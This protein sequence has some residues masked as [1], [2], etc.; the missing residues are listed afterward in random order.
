MSRLKTVY[1]VSPYR[2]QWQHYL[3]P[4]PFWT[5]TCTRLAT[6]PCYHSTHD[7]EQQLTMQQA[8]LHHFPDKQATYKFTLRD[9]SA[10]FTRQAFRL[11][12]ETVNNF[13]RLALTD[14]EHSWLATS[15][16]YLTAEYLISLRNFRFRPQEQVVLTFVPATAAYDSAGHIEID[17][18]GLWADTIFWE[19][20]LMACLSEIYFTHVVTDWSYEGQKELAYD[21]ATALLRADCVFSEFGT[22]RRRSFATQDI[23]LKSLIK[24]TEDVK[25]NGKLAG[26][27]NVY[28][29]YK[30]NLVPVGTIAQCRVVYGGQVSVDLISVLNFNLQVGR[31]TQRLP[32]CQLGRHGSVGNRVPKRAPHRFDRYLLERRILQGN[33]TDRRE[34]IELIFNESYSSNTERA[35]RWQGLR[36]DSGDPFAFGIKAKDAFESL[37]IDPRSKTVIYSDGLSVDKS[38]RLKEQANELG[39]NVSFG[40]GTFLTNDFKSASG[41]PSK[42]LNMVIK[43]STIDGKPCV[44]ISD[45]LTKAGSS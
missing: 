10:L 44:K 11:F 45:D 9:K 18:S 42:A 26:T 16:P 40:I 14:E 3:S 31:S 25:S 24:A 12:Q 23:V 33:A 35:I 2:Q 37:N 1:L 34:A 29:A 15:C 39:L 6:F 22:R 32:R 8:V 30:Y 13:G 21:K 7:K 17:I 36:Q 4:G 38:L 19:V 20:P 27:S 43:L 28:L 5:Q 41:G